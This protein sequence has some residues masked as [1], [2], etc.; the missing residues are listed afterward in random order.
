MIL[1]GPGADIM[2]MLSITSFIS[3]SVIVISERLFPFFGGFNG[4]SFGE[5]LICIVDLV[6]WSFSLDH[7]HLHFLLLKALFYLCIFCIYLH[8]FYFGGGSYIV[9]GGGTNFVGGVT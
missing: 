3:S 4:M 9:G 2:V 8:I 6:G 1:S 7:P 5:D